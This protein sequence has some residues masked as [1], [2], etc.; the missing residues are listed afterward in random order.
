[1]ENLKTLDVAVVPVR[2]EIAPAHETSDTSTLQ[3]QSGSKRRRMHV[4][5][6]PP[7]RKRRNQNEWRFE[8]A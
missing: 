3:S 2:T 1:M 5:P 8:Q 7:F 4:L 6:L